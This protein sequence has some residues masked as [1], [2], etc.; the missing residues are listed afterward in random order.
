MIMSPFD[1]YRYYLALKLHFTTEKYDVIEQQGRIRASRSAFLKRPDVPLFKKVSETYT[2]KDVVDFLVANFTSGDKWGGIFDTEA[3]LRYVEWKKKRTSLQYVFET[4][5][6]KIIDYCDRKNIDY[7]DCFK[8]I[9]SQHPYII[10]L[11]LRKDISLE[12]LVILNQ[13][14]N[15]VSTL[16]EQLK[17]DLIWPDLSRMIRK[18]TPFLSINKEKFNEL[19]RKTTGCH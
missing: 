5:L 7:N 2:D 15:Y 9:E 14:N 19:A 18:Y 6:R 12:T 17:G 3:K 13:L 8:N 10:R 11:F 4:D 1:V 16:D